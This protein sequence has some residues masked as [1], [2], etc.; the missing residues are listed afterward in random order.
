[1]IAVDYQVPDPEHLEQSENY[2]RKIWEQVAEGFQD[3]D[4]HLIFEGMNKP[5][6]SLRLSLSAL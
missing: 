4:E 2:V 1:M 3:Y 6:L 5:R